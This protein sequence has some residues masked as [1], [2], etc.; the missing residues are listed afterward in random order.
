MELSHQKD[1]L[2]GRSTIPPQTKLENA[3]ES[4]LEKCRKTHLDRMAGLLNALRAFEFS[5]EDIRSSVLNSNRKLRMVEVEQL[6]N[7]LTEIG[8]NAAE[9]KCT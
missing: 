9:L 4:A 1:P 8:K 6:T 7:S 2:L 3:P 5:V